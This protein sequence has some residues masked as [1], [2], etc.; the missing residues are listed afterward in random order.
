VASVSAA[1]EARQ[2]AQ[3]AAMAAL[4]Q[5]LLGECGGA[6]EFEAARAK[7]EALLSYK[8]GGECVRQRQRTVHLVSPCQLQHPPRPPLPPRPPPPTPAG[9]VQAEL[10][11]CGVHM[12]GSE[13]SRSA[14]RRQAL[15]QAHV[16]GHAMEVGL[17]LARLLLVGPGGGCTTA[18]ATAAA[19]HG[20]G[21]DDGTDGAADPAG[22]LPHVCA[23]C[24]REAAAVA[25][26]VAQGARGRVGGGVAGDVGSLLGLL[27]LPCS[28]AAYIAADPNETVA[29]WVIDTYLLTTLRFLGDALGD[30]GVSPDGGRV[31]LSAEET[32]KSARLPNNNPDYVLAVAPARGPGLGTPAPNGDQGGDCTGSAAASSARGRGRGRGRGATRGS[33]AMAATTPR[34]LFPAPAAP[35]P[36]PGVTSEGAA[37][38]D[39]S[40]VGREGGAGVGSGVPP[41]TPSTP[42]GTTS[43]AWPS[44]GATPTASQR[45]RCGKSP[46]SGHQPWFLSLA[47][48][49]FQCPVTPVPPFVARPL[50]IVDDTLQLT[51]RHWGHPVL[52]RG[53]QATQHL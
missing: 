3:D 15:L 46:A 53:G 21:V 36:Q 13:W 20:D 47:G 7:W 52:R 9:I 44:P 10:K 23:T 25:R 6:A 11:K 30:A 2:A 45:G 17:D 22:S 37:F 35:S 40:E 14:G 18:T 28:P 33:A 32:W 31:V 8:A 29:R 19:S 49:C 43:A 38:G 48:A 34:A 16:R 26:R 4:Q 24:L 42:L 27:G 41:S 39:D 51:S 1:A 12:S 50:V 5:D